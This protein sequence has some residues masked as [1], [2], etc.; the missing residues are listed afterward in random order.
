MLRRGALAVVAVSL[1]VSC[2]DEVALRVGASSAQQALPQD[3]GPPEPGP[4]PEPDPEIEVEP[5][6]SPVEPPMIIG[7]YGCRNDSTVFL[8]FNGHSCSGVL[9]RPDVILTAAH[10]A[11]HVASAEAINVGIN[12]QLCDWGST[13][14]IGSRIDPRYDQDD[15]TANHDV[16]VV[17]LAN[18][19]AGGVVATVGAFPP[20]HANVTI[21]GFG[22]DGFQYPESGLQKCADT[23]VVGT[24]NGEITLG[25]QNGA[26][27]GDSGGPVFARGT[28]RVVG[29]LSNISDENCLGYTR[30]SPIDQSWLNGALAELDAVSP[31]C[32]NGA[33]QVCQPEGTQCVPLD[34]NGDSVGTCRLGTRTC[35]G[36]AWGPCSGYVGPAA[37]VCIDGLDQDC[38]GVADDGCPPAGGNPCPP[39]Y[40]WNPYFEQCLCALTVCPPG[41]TLDSIGCTCST[42]CGDG[43]C[44]LNESRYTCPIDCEVGGTTCICGWDCPPNTPNCGYCGDGNCDVVS[45]NAVTCPIDCDTGGSSC[46]CGWDCPP[47][48]PAC[49][50][51]CGD[52]ICDIVTENSTSC[53][54]D[55]YSGGGGPG[56]PGPG[57]GGGGC[58]D[59]DWDWWLDNYGWD[60]AF[61]VYAM[62][63][64]LAQ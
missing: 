50:G 13:R 52:G 29:I 46:I 51:Y 25:R 63:C 37:E 53:P 47:N 36:N 1:C 11:V 45:E 6:S 62:E 41:L 59:W 42:T 31:S 43:V 23:R 33:T 16:A 22:L 58:D 8:T 35:N 20:Y 49:Q 12:G 2:G 34:G 7:G 17:K 60:I 28:R 14:G 9:I 48:T 40:A 61:E 3:P 24:R 39:N 26:C 30:A 57:P 64:M 56:D 38:D 5:E 54:S 10:C 21:N 44:Q 18:P 27:Y 32:T 55:C 15:D 4:G 19:I